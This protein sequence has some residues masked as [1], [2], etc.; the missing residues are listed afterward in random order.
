MQIRLHAFCPILLLSLSL[1]LSLSLAVP[2]SNSR[3][4]SLSLAVQFSLSHFNSHVHA[5]ACISVAR[6]QN[7]AWISP[8]QV[9]CKDILPHVVLKAQNTQSN[10]L[11]VQG[12]GDA[13]DAFSCRSLSAKEPLI[14][15]LFRGK[16]PMKI[17]HPLHLRH[18][19]LKAHNSLA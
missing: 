12:G 15:R 18:P 13:Y 7:G 4:L 17:R 2:L 14:T 19:V 6:S 1:S 8:L 16:L 5:C 10:T 3:W 11:L 9:N